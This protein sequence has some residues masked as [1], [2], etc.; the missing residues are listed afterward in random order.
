MGRWKIPPS[1][2]STRVKAPVPREIIYPSFALH[3]LT[4]HGLASPIC[5]SEEQGAENGDIARPHPC[6]WL[7]TPFTLAA[8]RVTME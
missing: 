6:S 1:K 2:V 3:R 5:L 4:I 7:A 8:Q